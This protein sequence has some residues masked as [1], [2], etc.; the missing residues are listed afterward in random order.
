MNFVITLLKTFYSFNLFL[1]LNICVYFRDLNCQH[2][3]WDNRSLLISKQSL[4][5]TIRL[6]IIKAMSHTQKLRL[7][8]TFHKYNIINIEFYGFYYFSTFHTVPFIYS[9][10]KFNTEVNDMHTWGSVDYCLLINKLLGNTYVKSLPQLRYSRFY[11]YF[12]MYIF[13]G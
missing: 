3:C 11:F 7:H 8:K 4:Q 13:A 10:C 1:S 12:N 9:G 2:K 6:F 5:W